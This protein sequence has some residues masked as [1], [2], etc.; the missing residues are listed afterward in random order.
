MSACCSYITNYSSIWEDQRNLYGRGYVIHKPS[1]D[2][3][4]LTPD[5]NHTI[6]LKMALLFVACIPLNL[7]QIGLRMKHIVTGEWLQHAQKEALHSW[8]KERY[9][10][11][12]TKKG[13]LPN[14]TEL[15][16]RTAKLAARL[17]AE[18]TLKCATLPLATFLKMAVCWLSIPDPLL[19]RRLFGNIE[20][21]WTYHP[22]EET[23]PEVSWSNYNA[24]CM[25]PKRI[26]DQFNFYK[27][28][29]K[30]NL[31][32]IRS[33]LYDINRSLTTNKEYFS[34]DTYESFK[35]HSKL[36][37]SLCKGD[38]DL[39]EIKKTLEKFI[40]ESYRIAEQD[41]FE[42]EAET[43]RQDELRKAEQRCYEKIST[44]TK[45]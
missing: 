34:Q 16:W 5:S 10:C 21:A 1:D 36:A 32:D 29:K 15:K 31:D 13:P 8:R 17:F 39:I 9:L 44:Y 22:E 33:T 12:Q 40:E 7:M 38:K 45:Q 14:R 27:L 24:L 42:K 23:S 18:A 11:H 6:R 41:V 35:T 20:E 26:W 30:H 19:A 2:T 43:K 4:G 3:Y 25:Q 28:S 37:K